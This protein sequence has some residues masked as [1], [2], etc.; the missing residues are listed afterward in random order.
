MKGHLET[1]CSVIRTASSTNC[2]TT[3]L[4]LPEQFH[5][6]VSQYICFCMFKHQTNPTIRLW[7]WVEVHTAIK[8][9]DKRHY[10]LL[11]YVLSMYTELS[12][13][14]LLFDFYLKH[15]QVKGQ[16]E[17]EVALLSCRYIDTCLNGVVHTIR[18][19]VGWK[20]VARQNILM[21][22]KKETIWLF[23]L[24][25][26][27]WRVIIFFIFRNKRN[28]DSLCNQTLWVWGAVGYPCG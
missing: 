7:E 3:P 26:N 16:S 5:W 17:L 8:H 9:L 4:N 21:K 13:I 1:L 10:G 2:I 6:D 18:W 23:N 20:G 19:D 11:E 27:I 28:W 25:N 15:Q 24:W 22:R 12:C 14:N